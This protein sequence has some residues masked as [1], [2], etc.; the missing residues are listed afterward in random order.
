LL[1]WFPDY[2]DPDDYFSPFVGTEGSK[3]QGSFFHDASIDLEISQEEAATDP[4]A[5]DKIFKHLEK[6]I[7][8]R[9]VYVP[10]WEESEFVVTQ[11]S[12]S[13]SKLDVTSFLRAE[14]LT[15]SS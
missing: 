7:A 2:F 1:G 10:L 14:D 5:R 13:G 3:S 15:K 8:D 12:V 4:A 9:A 11:K 6:V